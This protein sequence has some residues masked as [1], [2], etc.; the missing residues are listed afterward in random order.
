MKPSRQVEAEAVVAEEF[1]SRAAAVA[2]DEEGAGE[3]ILLQF[4]L[5]DRRQAIDAVAKVCGA[6]RP[7]GFEAAG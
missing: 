4:P 7:A 2:K 1:E 6:Y 5:T 3:G